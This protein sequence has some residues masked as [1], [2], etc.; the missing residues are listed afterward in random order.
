MNGKTTEELYEYLCTIN[1]EKAKSVDKFNRRRVER[2]IYLTLHGDIIN[3][4]NLW[5]KSDSKYNFITIYIDMPRDLLYDRINKR[6]DKMVSDGILD[7]AKMLY[8]LQDRKD[9]TACQAIGY[10]EFFDYFD[11]KKTLE[12]CV[13]TIKINT[14][15]YAK[16]Q[17]TWFKK[18]QD[19]IIV[20]GT[21]PNSELVEQII[22][23]YYE[24]K[25]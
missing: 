18:L 7:E 13:E 5:K 4:N 14:R 12:E 15:H 8:N 20:D 17:I 22:K 23:E 9:S 3:E 24:N 19:K 16:R 25:T 11:N 21:R 1:K 10:K 2:A 6:V